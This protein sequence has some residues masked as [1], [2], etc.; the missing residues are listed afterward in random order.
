ME[1]FDALLTCGIA[2]VMLKRINISWTCLPVCII[3]KVPEEGS[4]RALMM[5]NL[6]CIK[7]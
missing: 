4:I 5:H 7:I 1:V 3:S 2:L 6:Q